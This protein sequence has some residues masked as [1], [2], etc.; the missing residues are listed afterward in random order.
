MLHIEHDL[1][2]KKFFT[3][4]DNHEAYVEYSIHDGGLDILHTIVPK[5]LEG[6]GIASQ[7]VKEAYNYAQSENLARL[8][9][10]PYAVAWLKK[11]Q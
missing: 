3:R 7:L 6:Q 10:C 4:I 8:A 11:H 2:N 9:T 5:P 1:E